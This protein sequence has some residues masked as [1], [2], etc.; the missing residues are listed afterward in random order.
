MARTEIPRTPRGDPAALPA[1]LDIHRGGCEDGCHPYLGAGWSVRRRFTAS[2]GHDGSAQCGRL[3]CAAFVVS[4]TQ[5]CGERRGQHVGTLVKPQ[6]SIG[7][8]DDSDTEQRVREAEY[9]PQYQCHHRVIDERPDQ[10]GDH[11]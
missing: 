8:C 10:C 3:F 5:L 9:Q 6:F 1:Q 7:Y 4:S 11:K 2:V